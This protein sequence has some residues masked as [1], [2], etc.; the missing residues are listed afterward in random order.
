METVSRGGR[1]ALRE[2]VREIIFEA[3]TPAGKTF[4]VTLIVLIVGSVAAVMLESIVDVKTEYDDWLRQAEWVITALFTLEYILRLWCVEA[5]SRYARS[6]FGIVDLLAILPTYMSLLLP[7]SQSLLVIR[8]LRLLRIFR[9]FKLAH[10]L[11]QANV[12]ATALRSSGPKVIVFMGTVLILIVI[13]GSAMYLVEGPEHGFT[14]IPRSMYWAIVTMTTVGYGDLAPE[15]PLGQVL[16]A[17]VMLMGYSIIAVPTGIVS[18]E[19]VQAGRGPI[20]TRACPT[21]ASEG[22]ELTADYCK[23]CGAALVPVGE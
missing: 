17:L 21:C 15:T 2:R 13:T 8:A 10:Y 5:P 18:A 16:A 22:H 7:G 11:G 23:D 3:D 12:L 14:S 20:T 9:V 6:F 19:L 4:D 1:E